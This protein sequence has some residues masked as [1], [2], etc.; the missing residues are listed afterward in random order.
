M[1]LALSYIESGLFAVVLRLENDAAITFTKGYMWL[2]YFAS[3][4]KASESA[5]LM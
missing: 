2:L 5:S 1:E 4:D 3:R